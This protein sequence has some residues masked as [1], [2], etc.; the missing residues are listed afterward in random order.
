MKFQAWNG[1]FQ[2]SLPKNPK[3]WDV[4]EGFKRESILSDVKIRETS[5]GTYVV[6]KEARSQTI[7]SKYDQI[8]KR[9]IAFKKEEA[10]KFLKEIGNMED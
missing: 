2:R 7:K 5:D 1:H 3:I 10:D 8:K 9:M 4:F 6:E